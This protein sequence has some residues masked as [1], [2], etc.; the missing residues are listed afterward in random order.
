[1]LHK[2][3]GP[4][5]NH[6]SHSWEAS[7]F[8]ARDAIAVYSGDVGKI[9]WQ[10][11]DNTFWVLIDTGPAQWSIMGTNPEYV[12]QVYL[13]TQLSDFS[14]TTHL[15]DDRYTTYEQV[16]S[17][18]AALV[19]SAPA[20][21]D[22][23]NELALALGNDPNFATTVTN[24]LS[25]KAPVSHQHP[26]TDITNLL[27][28]IDAQVAMILKPGTNVTLD[29]NAN[30]ITINASGTGGVTTKV[31]KYN[32][33]GLLELGSGLTRWYPEDNATIIA[34]YASIGVVGTS[35]VEVDVLLNGSSIFYEV[36]PQ[37][38]AGNFRSNT[39][40][41]DAAI[42]PADAITVQVIQTGGTAQ[43][44]VVCIVYQ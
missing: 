9:C 10:K 36:G 3:L 25:G 20:A 41:R 4:N 17:Y 1:M 35:T 39:I 23:L 18:V 2:E 29:Q 7:D 15:H 28:T 16:E 5:Q 12:T 31:A 42:T 40:V 14:I 22:T 38:S 8:A 24:T 32:V 11:D 30:E 13:D 27:P 33:T 26:D 37:I 21:L 19:D 34:V 6:V 44:L 43:N